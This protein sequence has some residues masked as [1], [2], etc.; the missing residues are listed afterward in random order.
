MVINV[1]EHLKYNFTIVNTCV[2]PKKSLAYYLN[3]LECFKCGESPIESKCK[4]NYSAQHLPPHPS[5][6]PKNTIKL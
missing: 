6:Y 3:R 2:G 4:M 1:S 5:L